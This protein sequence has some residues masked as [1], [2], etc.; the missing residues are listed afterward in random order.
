[1]MARSG[2]QIIFSSLILLLVSSH[3]WTQNIT[4]R[5]AQTGAPIYYVTISGA[6]SGR[7]CETNA[8]GM[9]VADSIPD[10]T[11]SISHVSYRQLTLTRSQL[12]SADY[13]VFLEPVSFDLDQ[14]VVAATRWSQSGR[15]VPF[16]VAVLAQR[17]I[18][19]A[20]PQSAADLIG[21]SG[22]V[23]IQKSQQGGGSP[24]IRG[25]AANRLLY[26][27]DGVRMN[28]AIFRSGNL[29]NV[30]SLDA[31]ST[32]SAEVLFGPGAVMYG[33]DAIGGVMVFTTL[34]PEYNTTDTKLRLSGNT[35]MRYSSASNEKTGHIDFKWS[36]PSW[37]AVTSITYSDFQ[38]LRMGSVGPDSYLKKWV[39]GNVSGRDTILLNSDP[40]IQNPSGYAQLNILQK[41]KYKL[42]KD[43][44][45]EYAFHY[46]KTSS[47][48]RYDR[49][50]RYQKG[51]P[52]YGE[53]NYG[54]Q[55]W[56]MHVLS[57]STERKQRYY[58]AAVVRLSLQHFAESRI[59][60]NIYAPVRRIREEQVDALALTADFK[61]VFSDDLQVNYG[62]EVVVNDVASTG[63]DEN[64]VTLERSPA[65]ARYPQALWSAS[66][67]FGA[68][69]YKPSE[70]YTF[71]GGIRYTHYD[72]SA[73]YDTS[74]YPFPF[75]LSRNSNGALSGHAGVVFKPVKHSIIQANIS[76][77]FRA[78]NVDDTGKVFDAAPGF[79]SV[80]N[81]GLAAEYVY[82]AE[83]GWIQLLGDV[84]RIDISVYHTLLKN[85][86]VRRPFLFNGMDSIVY[87]GQLSRVEAIQN[88]ARANM[89]GVQLSV[90][91]KPYKGLTMHASYNIQ[92]GTEELDNGAESPS[93]HAAPNFGNTWISW[94]YRKIKIFMQ[95]QYNES[96]TFDQ[97]AEEERNKPELYHKD[98]Q[99][100]PWSPAWTI[101]NLRLTYN[102][103]S[104][105]TLNVGLENIGDIRYRTYSSGIAAPGRN[106]SVSVTGKF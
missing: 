81:P 99:G 89:Q 91:V 28:T 35:T 105:L 77:G 104:R 1:M 95:C 47:F 58:D 84:A 31:F 98:A 102:I 22:K 67:A 85:A 100:R 96:K 48:A 72:L 36:A 53:W 23:F 45:A 94:E 79:V 68:I 11:F 5:D 14:V 103:T 50:I 29:H 82:N 16:R 73:Q 92:R 86:L 60:R 78:P 106:L 52:R 2:V 63:M 88:A 13:Q 93:R 30:I 76:S 75:T 97:L 7:F 8:A 27:I 34:K 18:A 26:S 80:P 33:S 42:H 66:G 69:Q 65:P 101:F 55:L 70:K 87:D 37:S 71:Q 25:F 39:A 57:L 38:N 6:E 3:V 90:E 20:Q 49:H 21:L 83:L 64:I 54:P 24:M 4:V 59:E 10:S 51:L 44:D 19:F 74:F 62:L 41:I 15:D 40:R 12:A 17:D 61:K 9:A 56:N 46:S 43:W 32:A